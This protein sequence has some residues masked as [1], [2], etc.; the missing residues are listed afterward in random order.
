MREIKLL[1]HIFTYAFR[2]NATQS[3]VKAF[4]MVCLRNQIIWFYFQ[5]LI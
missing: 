3:F 1:A 4:D 2:R 5:F